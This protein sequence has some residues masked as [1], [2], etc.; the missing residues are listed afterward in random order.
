MILL[1]THVLIWWVNGDLSRLS[2]AA[3]AAI[4]SNRQSNQKQQLLVSAISCWEVAMLLERGRLRLSMD[5]EKWFNLISAIPAIKFLPLQPR[6]AINATQLPVPFHADPADRF[7]VAQARQLNLPLVS[8]DAR[9]RQYA[10]VQS[11][12]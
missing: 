12:W 6:V 1:D 10:H 2:K 11:I 8:A 3:L 4:E 7:L 5:S 9:I